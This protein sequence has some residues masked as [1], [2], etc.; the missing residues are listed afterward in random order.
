MTQDE[1]DRIRGQKE[2]QREEAGRRLKEQRSKVAAM[3]T[4]LRR[5]I[6]A[7]ENERPAK[8]PVEDPE[9]KAGNLALGDGLADGYF[10][11]CFY[12]TADELIEALSTLAATKRE[13]AELDR[14]L[15]KL[16]GDA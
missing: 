5:V 11:T 6:D 3:A 9:V 14:C 13:V 2:R 8:S 10:E 12:P 7:L 4:E 16:R 1:L 15:A